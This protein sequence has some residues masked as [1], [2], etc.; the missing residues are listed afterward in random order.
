MKKNYGAGL[1]MAKMRF[2]TNNQAG[3]KL[4]AATVSKQLKWKRFFYASLVLNVVLISVLLL[5]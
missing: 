1:K 5:K 3:V 2:V 4:K